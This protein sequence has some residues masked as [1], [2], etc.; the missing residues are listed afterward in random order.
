MGILSVYNKFGCIYNSL[1]VDSL[2]FKYKSN[3]KR[4]IFAYL[5]RET[6][7]ARFCFINVHHDFV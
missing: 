7:K 2:F 1:S 6:S 3:K 5:E 4:I